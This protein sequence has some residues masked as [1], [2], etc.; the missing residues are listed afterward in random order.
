VLACTGKQKRHGTAWQLWQKAAS[1]PAHVL[2]LPKP[3]LLLFRLDTV[4]LIKSDDLCAV[5]V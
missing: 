5:T 2:L 3:A 4:S 1:L